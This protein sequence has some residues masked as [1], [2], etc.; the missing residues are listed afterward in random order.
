MANTKV[1]IMVSCAVDQ[2]SA[3]TGF[4][5]IKLLNRLDIETNYPLQQTCCGKTAYF[6]GDFDGAK[7][8]GEKM[9]KDF[10]GKNP[11]ICTS[12]S[13]TAFIKKYFP[14]IFF[15]TACHHEFQIFCER[16]CDISDFLVNRMQIT[17]IGSAVFPHKVVFLDNC[18]TLNDYGIHD[19]PRILLQNVK[20]L[21]LI[22]LQDDNLACCGF[23]GGNFANEFEPISTDM[24]RR[25]IEN[26]QRSGATHVAST[27]MSCLLH[28]KSYCDKYKIE[29]HFH[30]IIDILAH[31]DNE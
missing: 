17:E 6:L 31:Q 1:D 4:N 19:E 8:L 30:H 14:K 13:C 2:F 12:S 5:L 26:I 23:G 24:A 21:E 15:N 25:K 20:G 16:I 11:V 3:Q 22:E 10:E 18:H 28:L 27:D 29:M 9:M 7:Q